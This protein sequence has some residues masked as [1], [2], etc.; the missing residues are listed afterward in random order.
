MVLSDVLNNPLSPRAMLA[1]PRHHLLHIFPTFA[2]GGVQNRIV[3]IMNALHRKYR[4]TIVAID[5]NFEAASLLERGLDVG[6]EVVPM[7]K[8]AFLSIANIISSR[9][10]LR[11]FH[12]NLLLTYN[13]GAT[14]W[15]LAD[16]MP[17]LCPHFH[18]ESGFG[19]DESP[20]RQHWRRI[21]ARRLLLARCRHI[22]V[23]SIVLQELAVRVWRMPRERVLYLPN[24]INAS[25][26]ESAPNAA[27][28]AA[29][30]IP[31]GVP[32]IGTVAALRREKNL[33]RLLRVF[34]ALPPGLDA[35]LVI[36]GDGPERAALHAAVASADLACRVIFAGHQ[37]DPSQ[38]VGRFDVFA[39][40]SDTEQMPNAIL[41]AMAAGRPVAATDVGDVKRM[42]AQENATFVVPPSDERAL[43][44]AVLRLVQDR[45][46]AS[47]VGSANRRRVAA[48]YSLEAMV[49]RYD[50]LYLSGM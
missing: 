5:G 39:L 32:V 4:H 42:L 46:L 13:W 20:Q 18:F 16:G 29:L 35:R 45:P 41:E 25:R 47:R 30:A 28:L 36:V 38:I 17:I 14:E 33:K 27:V 22:V 19:P 8:T 9:A 49:E 44:D 50:A 3:R 21:L 1:T 6:F 11:R 34:A 12:P 15:A 40:T 24:G 23:P 26:F 43:A 37:A 2:F 7:R 48:E 31:D 10:A